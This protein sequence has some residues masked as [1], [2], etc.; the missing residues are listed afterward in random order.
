[1]LFK[2]QQNV[3]HVR[4]LWTNS[5]YGDFIVTPRFTGMAEVSAVEWRHRVPRGDA[6]AVVM[7]RVCE[8][9]SLKTEPPFTR[10][11]PQTNLNGERWARLLAAGERRLDK[12]YTSLLQG[13]DANVAARRE[14]A[15]TSTAL[16]RVHLAEASLFVRGKSMTSSN[17]LGGAGAPIVGVF[18]EK[19][20]DV[21]TSAAIR[22]YRPDPLPVRDLLGQ[23]G[24]FYPIRAVMPESAIRPGESFTWEYPLVDTEPVQK[25][26]VLL[27]EVAQ[28]MREMDQGHHDDLY[29]E[30]LS[31]ESCLH[32]ELPG[33]LS[34]EQALALDVRAS[35]EILRN[36]SKNR[37]AEAS[38]MEVFAQKIIG[39]LEVLSPAP[40]STG[41]E[42]MARS[43]AMTEQLND[44][45]S[46]AAGV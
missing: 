41:I 20:S 12:F 42:T 14:V 46:P 44:A 36:A 23:D 22:L 21:P 9:G 3:L 24:C 38:H 4:M 16:S 40:I 7:F 18:C 45:D 13:F 30:A 19:D 6:P 26:R 17:A 31:L 37:H 1:M 5:D 15:L 35:C 34:R 8:V 29:D 32:G 33:E 25:L 39:E 28:E 43:E 11:Y 2:P 10:I 27:E